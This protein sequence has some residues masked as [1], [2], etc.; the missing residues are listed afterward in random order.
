M[1]HRPSLVMQLGDAS[2][3]PE[4][5][6]AFARRRQER[7]LT[8]DVHVVP[9]GD[10]AGQVAQDR[11]ASEAELWIAGP[12]IMTAEPSIVPGAYPI[13]QLS[14]M[15]AL[16]LSTYGSLRIPAEVLVPLIDARIPLRIRCTA[17]PEGVST[18][19]DA[20]GA[21]DEQRPTSVCSLRRQT[22]IDVQ[23]RRPTR[24][25]ELPRLLDQ[26]EFRVALAIETV[27][28]QGLCFVVP[29]A[30]ADRARA[31]VE[32]ALEP[33]RKRLEVESI[34]VREP[35]AVLT[36]VAEAM[37]QRARVAG[38]FFGALG[39]I[40]V[41]VIA[42]G[43][44]ASS[45]SISCVIAEEDATSAVRTVHDAFNFAHQT[46]NVFVLGRGVV[47]GEL[48]DQ[49]RDQGPIIR[50]RHGIQL[51]LVGIKDSRR[52]WLDEDGLDLGDDWRARLGPEGEETGAQLGET[53][54]LSLR[55]LPVPVLVDCTAAE[56]MGPFYR[57]VFGHG[58]HVVAANK[59]PL[60]VGQDARDALME[61]A[62]RHYRA[63]HYETTVGASL[64]VIETLKDL[65]RTGDRVQLI[66]GS[67]SGTLG[68]LT[69]ELSG[70]TP[71]AQAVR[72]AQALGYTEPQPQDDL[73]GLDAARKALILARE[74]GLRL[75][76]SDVALEP[77]VPAALLA[78]PD[79]ARFY[80]ALSAY[81]PEMSNRIQ[82][83]RAEGKV[84]RYLARID[85]E[86][87]ARGAPALS[88]GPVAVSL[89][90][91]A[92]SLRGS[93][94]IV[95]FTTARYQSYPLIVRGAGAGGAVTAA[96][97]LADILRVAQRLRGR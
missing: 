14:Y 30:D 2:A 29:S 50:E 48:I 89:D 83:L 64:P 6:A 76:M 72:T 34:I 63:Y 66:E 39:E 24:L 13:P 51:V 91:P 31:A 17:A 65:V 88:V 3:G 87:P 8:H 68:Y 32:E 57:R 60:T 37:G 61:A 90:H 10:N 81:E 94:A 93:E 38:R 54:L 5:V 69:H 78:E 15:E 97:V 21:G 77:L 23:L 75:D 49:I 52:M 92:A 41:N 58:I 56:D 22:L 85:P 19:V 12:A 95:A 53:A 62:R 74:L 35:V 20:A 47:G 42:I 11:G 70:G 55:R 86:A 26:S 84:L 36:L 45:R 71:L 96:G 7:A 4:V 46:V 27:S 79:P 33:W 73:S 44:S 40:G 16:E 25:H 18:W 9:A 1:A 80:D 28:G 82:A 43:Q 59:K 67:F